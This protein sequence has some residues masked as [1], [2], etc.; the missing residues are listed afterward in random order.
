MNEPKRARKFELC[1]CGIL[2]Q[3]CEHHKYAKPQK[4]RNNK[5]VENGNKKV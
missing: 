1:K 3:W 2:K 5:S 4:R